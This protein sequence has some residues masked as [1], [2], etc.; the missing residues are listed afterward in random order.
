MKSGPDLKQYLERQR[1]TVEKEL[2]R[3]LPAEDVPPAELHKAMRYSA[4]SPGKR[5][6]PI[7]A[8][9]GCEAV[10]GKPERALRAGCAFELVHAYS[11]VHDDLP[12]M[13]DAA[14]R[15]GRPTVHKAFGEAAAILAGDALLTLAFEVVAGAPVE[16]ARL[17]A[18]LARAA[19]SQGMVGGQTVDLAMEGKPATEKELEALH[20]WKTGALIRGAVVCGGICGRGAEAE[21]GALSDWGWLA[22]LAFQVADDLL[23]VEKTAAETGKDAGGDAVAGKATYPAILGVEGARAKARDLARRA[24][25]AAAALPSGGRLRELAAYFVERNS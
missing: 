5:L 10:G 15:R 1:A 11:L 18:E 17:A 25:E 22:G 21:L 20:R 16:P 3:L 13:D 14:L 7:L 2:E 19:G 9:M 8:L 4:M 23:D 12:A 6:R 24:G